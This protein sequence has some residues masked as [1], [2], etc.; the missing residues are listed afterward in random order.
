MAGIERFIPI[1]ENV[2]VNIEGDT[3]KGYL[4]TVKGPL[5]E[6]SRFLKFRG[7]YIEKVNGSIRIYAKEEREKDLKRWSAH[8][9]LT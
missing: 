2:E 7:V 8:S 1:P 4:I 3:T 9:G 6:N 5:G